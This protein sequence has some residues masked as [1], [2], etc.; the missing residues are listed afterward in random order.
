MNASAVV[1][2]LSGQVLIRYFGVLDR[3][4]TYFEVNLRSVLF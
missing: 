4:Y 2:K 1:R 3:Y